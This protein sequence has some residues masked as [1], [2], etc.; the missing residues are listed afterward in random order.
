M[1][2]GITVAMLILATIVAALACVNDSDCSL[3]GVCDRGQ[4][5][6]RQGWSG[7]DCSAL[8]IGV[9]NASQGRNGLPDSSSWGGNVLFVDG[10]YHLFYSVRFFAHM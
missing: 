7:E 4:C 8:K 10:V 1:A 3:N 5:V 6:C 9:V 2:S